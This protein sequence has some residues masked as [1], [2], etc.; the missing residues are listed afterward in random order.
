[1]KI[2]KYP[3]PALLTVCNPVQSID[4]LAR[5]LLDEIGSKLELEDVY[6][7]RGKVTKLLDSATD[8]RSYKIGDAAIKKG[9]DMLVKFLDFVDT[10]K[11]DK[12]IKTEVVQY[13]KSPG[14]LIC[15]ALDYFTNG[16]AL[17]GFSKKPNV[18]ILN[19]LSTSK[20]LKVK[21]QSRLVAR[22]NMREIKSDKLYAAYSSL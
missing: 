7:T 5:E 15:F 4:M 19:S 14:S 8:R 12:D 9:K 22:R 11:N 6:K 3:H 10:A 16:S 20:F 17:G 21:D 2:L 18:K 1:M 13:A